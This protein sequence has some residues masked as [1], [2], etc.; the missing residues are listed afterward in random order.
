MDESFKYVD[1][2]AIV[3]RHFE[4]F[5]VGVNMVSILRNPTY[6]PWINAMPIMDL[7]NFVLIPTETWLNVI[8]PALV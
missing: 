6:L 7:T 5:I 4:N 1:N 3:N 2:P 8:S